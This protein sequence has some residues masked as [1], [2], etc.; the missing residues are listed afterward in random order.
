MRAKTR[1][2]LKPVLNTLTQGIPGRIRNGWDKTFGERS[3]Y[4][5]V[6]DSL[7]NDADDEIRGPLIKDNKYHNDN[8]FQ[9]YDYYEDKDLNSLSGPFYVTD[10]THLYSKPKSHKSPLNRMSQTAKDYNYDYNYDYAHGNYPRR[11]P[12]NSKTKHE[13]KKD[14]K[15]DTSRF[16]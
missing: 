8:L 13:Y 5:D 14:S 10:D 12:K 2:F 16:Y 11:L 9:N 1:P 3:D 7:Y 4:L 6:F 15:Y